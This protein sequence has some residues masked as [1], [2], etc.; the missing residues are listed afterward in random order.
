VAGETF[1]GGETKIRPGVYVRVTDV[2]GNEPVALPRGIVGAVI[3][4]SW[5]PLGTAEIV[6]SAAHGQSLYGANTILREA[7]AGGARRVVAVRAGSGGTKATRVLNASATPKLTLT[8]KHEGTRGNTFAVTKRVNPANAAQ[9]QLLVYEGTS[10]LETITYTPAAD[11]AQALVDAVNATSNFLDATFT[12]TGD[13]DVVSQQA[14]TG[15]ADPTVNGAAYT[16]ALAALEVEE[17]NVLAA[18]SEDTAIQATVAAFVTDKRAEG[19]RIIGVIGEPISVAEATRRANAAAFNK[20]EIVYVGNGFSTANGDLDGAEAA[21]RVAGMIAQAEVTESMTHKVVAGATGLLGGLTGAGVEAAINSGMLVFTRN[22]AGQVQIEY[23]ITTLITPGAGQD[24]GWKKIRRVRTRDQLIAQIVA[25]TDRLIGRVNNDDTGRALLI[26]GMQGA[27]NT[28]IS[29]GAL[30]AGSVTLDPANP[31]AG[32][33][34]WF[35]IEV[36][37][38]DSAEKVYLTFGFR[39]TPAAA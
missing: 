26:A 6:E 21:A 5:G 36:E 7:F 20:A 38:N 11:D 34:A 3:R 15:G 8:A 18:D 14:L 35:V 23:G 29:L 31:A 39:F 32:D 22:A 16:A 27:V 30:N 2:G 25:D 28:L 37:D 10:L 1:L 19:K 24:A 17:F 33:S 9:N 13:V 4:G 12:A